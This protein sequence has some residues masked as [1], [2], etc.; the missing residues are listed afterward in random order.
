MRED[1]SARYALYYAPRETTHWWCTWSAW[2]GRCAHRDRALAGGRPAHV[3]GATFD[4]LTTE[5]RRYGFHATL[6]PPFALSPLASVAALEIALGRW[7][8]MRRSVRL[9]ALEPRRL[10]PGGFLA[11]VPAESCA[12]LRTLADDCVRDFDAFRAPLTDA[13][14]ARRL[15]QPLSPAERMLLERWGYP[16]VMEAFRFHMTLT[17]APRAGDERAM[18][19]LEAAAR[20][21]LECTGRVPPPIDA[22]VLFEQPERGAPFRIRRRFPLAS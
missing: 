21:I 13:E 19:A 15:A 12:R 16:W 7:C 11:L 2:L 10:E 6:K 1:P 18:H 9:P 20:E 17:G 14:R 4:R 5:P 22:I 3:D 8:A